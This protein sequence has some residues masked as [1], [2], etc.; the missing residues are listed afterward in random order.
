MSNIWCSEVISLPLEC[1]GGWRRGSP[2]PPHSTGFCVGGGEGTTRWRP[3]STFAPDLTYLTTWCPKSWTPG[4]PPGGTEWMCGFRPGP[5]SVL[6]KLRCIS[7]SVTS[8]SLWP[9]R[10]WLGSSRPWDFPGKKTRVGCHFL[11]QGIF[12]TQGSNPGISH[13]KQTLYCLSPQGSP[14]VCPKGDC[15]W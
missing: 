1:G 2:P 3:G 4:N 15:N 12:L 14:G 10:L 9:H 6:V 11:L 7:P 5:R 8:S 13:C